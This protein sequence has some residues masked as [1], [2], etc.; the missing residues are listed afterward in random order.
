MDQ[1]TGLPV[2]CIHCGRC[3]EF[4]PHD[5]LEMVD[6]DTHEDRENAGM[7]TAIAGAEEGA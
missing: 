2:M 6:I 1:E 4:C 7:E 3:V 5:C